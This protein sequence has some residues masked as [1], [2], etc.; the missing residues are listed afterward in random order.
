MSKDIWKKKLTPF[1]AALCRMVESLT[2]HDTEPCLGGKD[3]YF[4]VIDYSDHPNDPDWLNAVLSAVQ[5][6]AGDRY[7]SQTDDPDTHQVV[8]HIRFDKDRTLYPMQIVVE[9]KVA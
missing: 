3:E 1:D 6:H 2:G 7:I 9:K 5:G 8:V 4:I